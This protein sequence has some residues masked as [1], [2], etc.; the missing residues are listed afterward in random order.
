M[1]NKFLMIAALTSSLLIS[2]T[3]MA[4]VLPNLNNLGV[5]CNS[6]YNLNEESCIVTKNNT[7]RNICP[8][9]VGTAAP[10]CVGLANK[11]FSVCIIRDQ[12]Q[13]AAC[14]ESQLIRR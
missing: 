11:T 6:Q 14:V 1:S 9:M 2:G 7:I 12:Q 13:K 8:K 3:A 10:D 4:Q 5:N